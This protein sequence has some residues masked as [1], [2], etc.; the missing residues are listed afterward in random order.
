MN[1]VTITA[2]TVSKDVFVKMSGRSAGSP[3]DIG[4][5]LNNGT[6]EK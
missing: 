6:C 2:F 4:R 3:M 5:E 1:A